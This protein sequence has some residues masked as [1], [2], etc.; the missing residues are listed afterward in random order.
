[1]HWCAVK[2]WPAG[3]SRL[4]AWMVTCWGW[5]CL[6]GEVF[7][8]RSVQVWVWVGRTVPPAAGSGRRGDSNTARWESALSGS[9]A[10]G[11][12]AQAQRRSPW[13][14]RRPEHWDGKQAETLLKLLQLSKYVTVLI[15]V[16]VWKMV[17]I[18]FNNDD[19][20][21]KVL[22]R[23]LRKNKTQQRLFFRQNKHNSLG[24]PGNSVLAINKEFVKLTAN[25]KPI[26]NE[27]C[28]SLLKSGARWHYVSGES[29]S[30]G[31]SASAPAQPTFLT[32]SACIQ[33]RRSNNSI[34]KE[35]G[36]EPSDAEA[37]RTQSRWKTHDNDTKK[38]KKQNSFMDTKCYIMV[39][40]IL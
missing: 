17:D 10:A 1:M 18:K 36:Y 32:S 33:Y 34:V 39:R 30:T 21:C 4:Y 27:K 7:S 16:I 15:Q 6:H 22:W 24:K 5:C 35:P 38:T 25:R 13:V 26:S 9:A 2:Q 23:S 3:D 19:P 29:L 11:S 14:Y 40:K 8:W 12:T 20:S 37:G 28:L 31:K